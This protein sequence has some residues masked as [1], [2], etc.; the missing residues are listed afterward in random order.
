M[1][2]V[3]TGAPRLQEIEVRG[4]TRGTLI[5]RGALAAGALYG[6]GSVAPFVGR[7]LAGGQTD[8]QILNFALMLESLEA[9]FYKEGL[10]VGLQGQ[11]K[12]LAAEFGKHE[13]EHVATLTKTIMM[14]GGTPAKMPVFSFPVQDQ[15]SFL[16]LAV[17]LEDTGVSAYNGAGPMLKSKEVLAAAGSIVQVEARHASAL[18]LAAKLDPIPDAFD[19]AFTMSEALAAAKPLIKS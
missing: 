8:V 2:K 12:K 16:A 11:V 17:T 9:A 14:L 5:L 6:A 10:K 1:L 15:Q 3:D 7:A 13:D 4:L 19:R 18:R